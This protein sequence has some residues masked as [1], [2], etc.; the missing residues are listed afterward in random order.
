M[1]LYKRNSLKILK[2]DY[3]KQTFLNLIKFKIEGIGRRNK[4]LL[5]IRIYNKKLLS[6]SS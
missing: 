5:L 3:L 2:Y 1:V 4:F 6:F